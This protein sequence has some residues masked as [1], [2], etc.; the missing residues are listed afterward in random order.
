MKHSILSQTSQSLKLR[1]QLSPEET[2]LPNADQLS[3]GER[4]EQLMQKAVNHYLQANP[5]EYARPPQLKLLSDSN[6]GMSFACELESYPEVKLPADLHFKLEVPALQAPEQSEIQAVLQSLQIQNGDQS[7][8]E[9]PSQW[10]DILVIDTMASCLA[11]YLPGSARHRQ[12][13]ILDPALQSD[14]FLA[15]LVGLSAGQKVEIT[16]TISE[17]HAHAA[18]RGKASRSAVYVHEVRSLRIP[19]AEL[20]AQAL[21]TE[22]LEALLDRLYQ[23]VKQAKMQSWREKIREQIAEILISQSVLNL[24]ASWIEGELAGRWKS[25]DE[26]ILSQLTTLPQSQEV[27]KKGLMNLKL[28]P[29]TAAEASRDLKLRVILHAIAQAE[30]LGLSGPELE[31]R[32]QT[33][34]PDQP[35]QET[36]SQLKER[37]EAATILGIWLSEKVMN[38]LMA[39]AELRCQGQILQSGQS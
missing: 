23:E 22:H 39:H 2:R 31:A 8:V 36:V 19:P 27:L 18:W 37:P 32:F 26:N 5:H 12:A 25:Q 4:Q 10:G 6:L 1:F 33:L 28:L 13:V 14:A 3:P 21:G 30:Q 7:L 15:G 16:Q 34:A 35:V 20:L 24:P 38:W 17:T 11:Q 9:R 29:Y